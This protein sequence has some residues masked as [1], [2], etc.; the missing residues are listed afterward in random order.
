MA[1][2]SNPLVAYGLFVLDNLMTGFD[3]AVST[4]A[5]RIIPRSELSSSLATGS[6]INHIFGVMVPVVGGILWEWFG[7]V[8]PFLMGVAIVLVAMAYS[9]NLDRRLHQQLSELPPTA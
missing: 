3:I 6:T 8:V 5:G 2:P 1:T 4:H 7:P 9:W